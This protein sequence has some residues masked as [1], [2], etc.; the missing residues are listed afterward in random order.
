MNI[1]NYLSVI[2][3]LRCIAKF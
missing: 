1:T 3:L 2:V